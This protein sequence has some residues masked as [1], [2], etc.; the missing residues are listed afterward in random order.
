MSSETQTRN[1]AHAKDGDGSWQ[2]TLRELEE[3][4]KHA[5]E[6]PSIL[7]KMGYRE[8]SV[9][10][11][12]RHSHENFNGTGYPDGLKGE[13]IPL[14]SR[15]IAVADVFTALKDGFDF[16]NFADRR[17]RVQRSVSSSPMR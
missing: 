5:S 16:S 3:I 1:P 4:R 10:E 13:E 12:I 15:I 7:K 17:M 2:N 9:F 14:G 8:E 6:G 11:M